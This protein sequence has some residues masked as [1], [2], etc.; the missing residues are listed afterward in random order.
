[1]HV[2]IITLTVIRNFLQALEKELARLKEMIAKVALT[3]G[4]VEGEFEEK[5]GD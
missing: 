2:I 4:L 5:L 3:Q 1:M